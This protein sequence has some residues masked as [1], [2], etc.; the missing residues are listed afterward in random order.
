MSA[1]VLELLGCRYLGSAPGPCRAG[2]NKTVAKS[3]VAGRAE[4]FAPARLLADQTK[5]V[6]GTAVAAHGALGLAGLSPID[7]IVDPDATLW[8]LA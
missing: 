2:W 7:M 4:F 8:F 6:A 3:P 5:A 1:A